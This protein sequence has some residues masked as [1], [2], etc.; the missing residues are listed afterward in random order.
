MPLVCIVSVVSFILQHVKMITVVSN[1]ITFSIH[2]GMKKICTTV[3]SLCWCVWLVWHRDVSSLF[4]LVESKEVEI[5][6][7]TCGNISWMPDP[8][9]WLSV[10]SEIAKAANKQFWTD[11]SSASENYVTSWICEKSR[12]RQS[13]WWVRKGNEAHHIILSRLNV[14]CYNQIFRFCFSL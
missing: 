14:K 12:C 7:K 11:E 9:T 10:P 13:S 2:I 1:S 3:P 8:Y 6:W 4:V 5:F